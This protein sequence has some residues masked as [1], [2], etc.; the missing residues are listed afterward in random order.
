MLTCPKCEKPAHPVCGNK[1]CTCYTRI[2]SGEKP[3]IYRPMLYSIILTKN[4]FTFL[5][6]IVFY[7]KAN[8][9]A[10]GL[11]EFME[12]PYCGFRG[13]YD[14]WEDREMEQ[15]FPDGINFIS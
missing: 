15:S 5:W 3:L 9:Y 2:P 6:K 7:F 10:L 11:Y 4:I 13:S 12:C 1:K 8:P 14:F